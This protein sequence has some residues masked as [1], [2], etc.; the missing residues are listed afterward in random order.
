[1]SPLMVEH[2]LVRD[3]TEQQRLTASPDRDLVTEVGAD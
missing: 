3:M 2:E 1:M